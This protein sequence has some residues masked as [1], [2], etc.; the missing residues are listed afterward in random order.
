[1]KDPRTK[2]FNSEKASDSEIEELLASSESE[3]TKLGRVLLDHTKREKFFRLLRWWSNHRGWCLSPPDIAEIWDAAMESVARN[4]IRGRFKKTGA[5][6]G[7]VRKITRCRAIDFL[8][9][10]LPIDPHFDLGKFSDRCYTDDDE[11]PEHI[12][13][14]R[15]RIAD[16]LPTLSERER[17]VMTSW[18]RFAVA[19]GAF[20]SVKVLVEEVN[21]ERAKRGEGPLTEDSVRSA[22]ARALKK[23]RGDDVDDVDDGEEM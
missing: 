15:Q 11:I 7:Y 13:E 5:I 21:S 16:A 6:D 22:K 18:I 14:L 2:D 8:R 12:L 1:V 17:D 19:N 9:R 20:P 4:V 23:L 3:D 10:R